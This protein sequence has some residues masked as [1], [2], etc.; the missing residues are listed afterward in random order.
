MIQEI[1]KINNDLRFNLPLDKT[2]IKKYL[3][4]HF[5]LGITTQSLVDPIIIKLTKNPQLFDE[6]V[7]PL[8][9]YDSSTLTELLKN[10]ITNKKFPLHDYVSNYVCLIDYQNFLERSL[11]DEWAKAHRN[12]PNYVKYIICK[13]IFDEGLKPDIN[14]AFSY[15]NTYMVSHHLG[16]LR[17]YYHY[18]SNP[19]SPNGWK[20]KPKPTDDN[21][22]RAFSDIYHE[23]QNKIFKNAL[24]NPEELTPQIYRWLKEIQIINYHPEYFLTN[25]DYFELE[26]D[27]IINGSALAQKELIN[28]ALADNQIIEAKSRRKAPQYQAIESAFDNLPNLPKLIK[29]FRPLS[30]EYHQDGTKK[31]LKEIL[32]SLNFNTALD[33]EILY[34]AVINTQIDTYIS[35]LDNLNPAQLQLIFD[36]LEL[37][38]SNSTLKIIQ[39]YEAPLLAHNQESKVLIKAGTNRQS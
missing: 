2:A 15:G 32:E 8:I 27:A 7:K 16:T 38:K 12:H 21:I 25:Q 26:I 39:A 30:K 36:A 37:K 10:L 14:T 3:D 6:L 31:S 22:I 28:P 18:F 4:T 5:A 9:G 24:T 35:I 20:Q 1:E 13:R 17:K 34:Q 11:A 33:F 29:F 19:L 23:K